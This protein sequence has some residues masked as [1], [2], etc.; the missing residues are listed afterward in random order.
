MSFSA[1]DPAVLSILE[2]VLTHGFGGRGPTAG[3][4]D[5]GTWLIFG[6][7]LM[8]VY[9]MIAAWFLGSP[10]K[11]K[12]AAMGVGYLVIITTVLWITM[13]FAMEVVGIIF[14]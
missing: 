4:P 14:Y 10:R 12:L 5:T 11:P 9:V 13:F 8:P 2:V 3:F 1:L 6:I 7:I